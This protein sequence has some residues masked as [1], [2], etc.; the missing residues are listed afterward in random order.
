MLPFGAGR[1]W[2]NHKGVTNAVLGG[3]QV[4]GIVTYRSGFPT[5]IRSSRVAAAN[6]MFA[7]FNVPDRVN[8]VSMYLPNPGV[9]G[10]S[11]RRHLRPD[12]G[13]EH[14]RDAITQSA[15]RATGGK[16]AEFAEYGFLAFKAFR[17]HERVTRSSAPRHST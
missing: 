14:Q 15:T 13:E 16:R 6:Q 5:D 8:G 12:V 2:L 3:W 1:P 17:I 11:N 4:N 7:T 9:D 10:W